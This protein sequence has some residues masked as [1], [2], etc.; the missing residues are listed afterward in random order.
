MSL[1][2][3]CV[4]RGARLGSESLSAGTVGAGVWK[5]EDAGAWRSDN[6][7]PPYKMQMIKI[8][9]RVAQNVGKVG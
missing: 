6:L 8:K 9:V 7:D 4:G 2:P 3:G 1:I 5:A